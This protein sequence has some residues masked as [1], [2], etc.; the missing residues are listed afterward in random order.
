MAAVT[1]CSDF[2][3]QKNKIS[4]CF[5]CFP[6]YLPWSDGTG[7]HDCSFLN[8]EF[9]LDSVL[10]SRDITLPAKVRLVKAMV[11][12]VVV[13]GCESCTIKKAE[14]WKI[15]A[16][17]LWC[18]RRLLRIPWI[19]RRSNQSILKEISPEYSLEGLMLKLKFPILWPPDAKN[20]LTR[21]DSD[22][23]KIE[24]GRR[25]RRQNIERKVQ[26][27]V[28]I[29]LSI[30]LGT[31]DQDRVPL[32]ESLYFTGREIGNKVINRQL[33]INMYHRKYYQ[34]IWEREWLSLLCQHGL[35]W[36]L[37]R[38]DTFAERSWKS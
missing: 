12:P 18:W 15:D 27:N 29:G 7:Y 20:W 22:A 6:I 34:V 36:S 16:F 26:H 32:P 9:S 14:Y 38:R 23:G 24:G 21:K 4:H 33:K 11:F 10:K 1:I 31:P 35:G 25:R 13:Y 17:E 28:T 37:W 19:A 5:H 3:A 2:G 8:V 30:V